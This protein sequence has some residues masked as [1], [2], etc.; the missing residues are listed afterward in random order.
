MTHK[1]LKEE[2]LK[3]WPFKWSEFQ[4]DLFSLALDR[5]AREYAREMVGEDVEVE[6]FTKEIADQSSYGVSLFLH[7]QTVSRGINLAKKEIRERINKS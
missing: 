2:L 7:G 1:E 6:P 4:M 5:Y 3:T